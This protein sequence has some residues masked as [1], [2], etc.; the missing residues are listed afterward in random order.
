MDDSKSNDAKWYE[1]FKQKSWWQTLLSTKPV[2]A[3]GIVLVPV[4]II[5][6][7]IYKKGQTDNASK[8]LETSTYVSPVPISKEKEAE[9]QAW[10][11]T[12]LVILNKDLNTILHKTF[13]S[14]G[15]MIDLLKETSEL[16]DRK[17]ITLQ[18]AYQAQ[19]KTSFRYDLADKF[20]GLSIFGNMTAMRNYRNAIVTRID[21]F[22]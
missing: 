5:G 6:Y 7:F 4:G 10:R 20:L 12:R 11:R 13:W 19:F 15:E 21:G 3:F 2:L 1:I 22:K 18:S 17:L 9:Y 8:T 16:D 14:T